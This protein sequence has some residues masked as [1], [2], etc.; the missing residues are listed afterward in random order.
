MTAFVESCVSTTAGTAAAVDRTARK[1]AG[2]E[3]LRLLAD[4]KKI[5]I[6]SHIHPDP[7]A[8]AS[9]LALCTLLSSRIKG[10]DVHMSIKGQIG[11]GINDAFARHTTARASSRGTTRD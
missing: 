2:Q 11:G 4:R 10:A 9:A 1:A 7:D 3:L 6:T 8:L 5:L